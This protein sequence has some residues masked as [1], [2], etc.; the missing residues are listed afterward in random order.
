MVQPGGR[1]LP[2][3]SHGQ[4]VAGIDEHCSLVTEKRAFAL[5]SEALSP[6]N[7]V[8]PVDLGA[9]D[10]QQIFKPSV[11]QGRRQGEL[12]GSFF[13]LVEFIAVG[14]VALRSE[15]ETVE[16][17]PRVAPEHAGVDTRARRQVESALGG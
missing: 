12:C 14:D 10:H 8:A 7:K 17:G 13:C 9:A 2:L 16:L 11:E 4:G 3:C 15:R 1:F 5:R 6:F